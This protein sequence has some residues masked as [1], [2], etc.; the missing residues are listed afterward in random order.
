MCTQFI[1]VSVWLCGNSRDFPMCIELVYTLVPFMANCQQQLRP[2]EWTCCDI[3]RV[4]V[5]FGF[6]SV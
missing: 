1:V 6:F 3:G 5:I 2:P 4:Q